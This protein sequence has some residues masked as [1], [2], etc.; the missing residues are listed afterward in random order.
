MQ[1]H[2]VDGRDCEL[3]GHLGLVGFPVNAL[4]GLQQLVVAR[5]IHFAS[6]IGAKN[7][8]S[9]EGFFWGDFGSLAARTFS[10]GV[11]EELHLTALL[12][13]NVEV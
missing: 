12:Q 8:V 5:S 9:V 2:V 4:S 1:G 3:S 10:S 7:F 6:K 11:S 13:R